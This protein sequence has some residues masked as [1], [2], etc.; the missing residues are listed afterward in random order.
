MIYKSFDI[1]QTKND[2][3]EIKGFK[4]DNNITVVLISDEKLSK[5][6]CCVGVHT[7]YSSDEF[8]GTAHFLEHLLFLGNK[9]NLS[10]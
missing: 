1:L 6:S 2:K 3:R 7:G 8:S 9:K 4:L 10:V 5:S